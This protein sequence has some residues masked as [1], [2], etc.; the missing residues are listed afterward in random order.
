MVGN[1]KLSREFP[2]ELAAVEKI[3]IHEN[4][5]TDGRPFDVALL[6]VWLRLFIRILT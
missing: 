3:S 6:E 4:F 1:N 2:S 5:D